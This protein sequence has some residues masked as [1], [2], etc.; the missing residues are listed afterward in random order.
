M[1]NIYSITTIRRKVKEYGKIINAPAR[2]LRVFTTSDGFGTPYIEIGTNEYS[3]I[4]SERGSELERRR[5]NDLDTL[6]YWILSDIVSNMAEEWELEHRKPNEDSRRQL[7]AKEI[8]L[9]EQLE[10]KF[11]KWKKKEIREIL[12]KYPYDDEL[13]KNARKIDPVNELD[14]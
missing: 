11:A 1:A 7:F 2:S 4:I 3:Y 6:L 12:K 8:E 14:S 10:P 13:Y 9:M 5:T